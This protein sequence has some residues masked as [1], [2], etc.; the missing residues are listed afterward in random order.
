MINE[1]E[2]ERKWI[3]IECN[4]GE[5]E[6]KRE[7]SS[8]RCSSPSLLLATRSSYMPGRASWQ[9]ERGREREVTQHCWEPASASLRC[10]SVGLKWVYTDIVPVRNTRIYWELTFTIHESATYIHSVHYVRAIFVYCCV[11][12]YIRNQTKPK[13]SRV[14]SPKTVSCSFSQSSE[15][16]WTSWN[17]T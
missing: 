4:K 16:A 14:E 8:A 10:D 15:I 5:S 2:W 11:C 7:S 9:G 6:N 1:K 3:P 13:V 12:T 17:G